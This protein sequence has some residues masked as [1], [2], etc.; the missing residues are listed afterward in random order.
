MMLLWNE[1]SAAEHA[2]LLYNNHQPN[3]DQRLFSRT[4]RLM[5]CKAVLADAIRQVAADKRI[6]SCMF[7]GDANCNL[8]HLAL[9]NHG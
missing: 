3:S 9:C 7:C 4:S 6:V 8:S 5:F 1:G 2:I